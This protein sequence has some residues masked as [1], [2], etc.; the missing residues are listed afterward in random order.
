MNQIDTE[1]VEEKKEPTGLMDGVKANNVPNDE[2][3]EPESVP[4]LAEET[5]ETVNEEN[6]EEAL[7]RPDF[8]PE[9]FWADDGP[10]LEKLVNSY[11]ELEK[12]FSQGK[13]KA[14]EKYNTEE[15]EKSFTEDDPLL[16]SY[17]DWSKKYNISQAAFDEM[18][19]SFSSIMKQNQED[20]DFNYKKEIQALGQNA[21]SIIQSTANWADSMER[22]GVISGAEREFLNEVGATAMGQKMLQKFRNMSGD[23]TTIPIAAVSEN[24]MS[25]MDFEAEI[26]SMMSDKRYGSD[27]AY[28][29]SVAKKIYA[30]KGEKFPE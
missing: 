11:Q 20:M 24:Q 9:K 22:K 26:Q 29:N 3:N 19:Q 2:S 16:V 12:K 21:E 7:E 14:P 28:T 13:H 30:R 15:L 5:N 6:K 1:I 27:M 10:D 8:F 4:H 18:A 25:E 23:M 17:L